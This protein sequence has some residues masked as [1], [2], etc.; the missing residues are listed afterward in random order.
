MKNDTA[1]ACYTRLAADRAN[2][3]DMGIRAADLTLPYLLT[4]LGHTNGARLHSPWQ[5]VGAK[6]GTNVLASKM[7]LS[8]FPI[9]TTFF[10]LQINDEELMGLPGVNAE[11]RSDIDLSLA[12]ME[13]IIMEQIADSNDRVMLHSA[14]KHLVVTGN[15]LVYMAKKNLKVY[16]LDRYVVARDGNG[17]VQ[18]IVTM[19]IVD[20]ELL[21]AKFQGITPERDVNSPGEDGP[22]DISYCF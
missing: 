10:K 8:L 20:R 14:M 3:L 17:N 9:N 2:F 15:A 22:K 18:E 19:E 11:V 1:Q 7:M 21:P 6:G 4:T 12:K 5:S 13:K 16:P